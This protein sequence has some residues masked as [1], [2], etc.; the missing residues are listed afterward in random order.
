MKKIISL[1]ALLAIL[2]TATCIPV[3]AVA[4]DPKWIDK[5]PAENV[6]YSFA[7]VGDT[8]I[9]TAIDAQSKIGDEDLSA[10]LQE[11]T[12]KGY[13][14]NLYNW[15]AEN[16]A[17]KKIE[18]VLG[19][20]DLTQNEDNG[21]LFSTDYA[22][23]DWKVM[24][25]AL[26][27]LQGDDGIPYSMARGNHD[28]EEYFNAYVGNGGAYRSA[29]DGAYAE[30]DVTSVYKIITIGDVKY[31]ILT[32]ELCPSDDEINWAK[33]II[34]ANTDCKVI[35]NTHAYMQ[36]NGAYWV[37]N[38][39]HD[40][41][42]SGNSGQKIW[43]NLVSQYENIFMV[44]CGHIGADTVEVSTAQG[45]NGKTVYQVL[46][47]PQD[48]E[49]EDKDPLGTV[50]LLNFYE[51]GSFGFEY[52]STVKNKYYSEIA[53]FNNEAHI[54]TPNVGSARISSTAAGLR[55][56]TEID[57]SYLKMLVNTYGTENVEV[58]T[59]I[60]PTDKLGGRK[61]THSLGE[62]GK[63]YI[64]VKATI[65]SPNDKETNDLGETT[66]IYSG[67]I[68]NIKLSNQDRDYTGVG[69]IKYT[70][71]DGETRYIYSAGSASR[72]VLDV[73]NKALLDVSDTYD[74]EAYKYVAEDLNYGVTVYSKYTQNQRATL[75]TLIALA[76]RKDP[77]GDDTLE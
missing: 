40:Y 14:Y 1:I 76:D 20:G 36:R 25:R 64:V 67:S 21:G 4:N 6:A 66:R 72:N 65:D 27:L 61:L 52:Y 53:T 23:M 18:Y 55:F 16:K 32:L 3:S 48:R 74:A 28:N 41:A 73:A 62:A 9:I 29:H 46:V 70:T 44:I 8:Q 33:G 38:N 19:V 45:K 77:S 30:G 11:S 17:A 50:A 42:S 54:S 56:K 5:A 58:G 49:L 69:Y 60:A 68:A 31:L 75:K 59:L 37:H 47:N 15:I 57:E 39:N 7:I 26:E 34:A 12:E 2:L 22:E 51:D 10:F 13:V 35:I 43:E 63:D 71:Y 24:E